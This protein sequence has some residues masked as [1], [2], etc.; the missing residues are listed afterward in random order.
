LADQPILVARF[1]PILPRLALAEIHAGETKS[2]GWA[3]VH[4]RS[5]FRCAI[6]REMPVL[7]PSGIDGDGKSSLKSRLFSETIM[8]NELVS[9]SSVNEDR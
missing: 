3:F 2:S 1:G 7:T 5:K 9:L 8:E 6:D 4:G